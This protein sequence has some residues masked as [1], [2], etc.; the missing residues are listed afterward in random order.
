MRSVDA[1]WDVL[2]AGAGVSDGEVVDLLAHGLQCAALL[3]RSHP[4][5][6]ELQVAG[7]VHDVGTVVRPDD[8]AGHAAR[9]ARLVRPVLGERV[10]WLVGAH[11]LAKRWLVTHDPAYRAALSPVSVAT[12]AAQGDALGARAAAAFARHR[13]FAAAVALRRADDAAKDPFAVVPGLAH[14]RATV[15]AQARA[16]RA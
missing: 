12:L 16:R 8:P 9:G 10:A 11:V 2:A 7:L 4:G 15:E 14:W 13:W 5:D 3:A 1:L 6:P